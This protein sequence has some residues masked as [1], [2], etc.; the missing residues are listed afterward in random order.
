MK[1]LFKYGSLL[2]LI[3]I[4]AATYIWFF[5]Y[6]KPH[7]DYETATPDYTLQAKDCYLSFSGQQIFT[8]KQGAVN[9]T[10][11][12][13]Q[14]SGIASKVETIDSL[15]VVVFVYDNGVFGDEG[16]RCTLLPNHVKTAKQFDFSKEITI[17][18]FCAGYNDTDV[19]LQYCSIIN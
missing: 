8:E 9:Y 2:A 19:I 15:T 17:K 1:K 10:G 5:V 18:G 14:L 13:L 3:G 7:T 11:K 12:V 4:L 6:N 16:I